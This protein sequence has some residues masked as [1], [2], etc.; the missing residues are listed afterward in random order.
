MLSQRKI[1]YNLCCRSGK[2][3]LPELKKPPDFLA[4]LLKF[5]GDTRSKRFIRQI[6]SYNSM[7]AFTS[8]GA[9]VDKMIN[10]RSAPCVFK[11][12][13]VVHHRI[14]SLLPRHGAAPKF[15]QLYIYDPENET[16]NRMNIFERDSNAVDDPDPE[17]V[18]ELTS[19]LD[20]HN[21]LVKAFCFARDRLKDHGDEKI[22]LRLLG[23]DARDEIQYNLPTSGEIAGIVV[24][25]YS[26]GEYTYDVMV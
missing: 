13:G 20:S 6:R 8:L 3:S 1:I 18:T 26:N 14:G 15:A 11:I 21:D 24:G 7:F 10:S 22:S 2:I 9:N 16:S 19:M 12:N 23:C 25:D 4:R 17:I 5:D